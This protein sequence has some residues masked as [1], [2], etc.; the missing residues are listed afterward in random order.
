MAVDRTIRTATIAIT[1]E[2]DDIRDEEKARVL[3]RAFLSHFMHIPPPAGGSRCPPTFRKR[4]PSR[5]ERFRFRFFAD[6]SPSALKKLVALAL[7]FFLRGLEA[8]NA[9]CDLFA[10]PRQTILSLRDDH[11]AAPLIRLA[12]I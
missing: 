1:G 9:R 3:P 10:L 8:R 2:R 5:P 4:L 7:E 6:I 11:F 12:Y